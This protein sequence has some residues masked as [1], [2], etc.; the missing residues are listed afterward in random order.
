MLSW[1]GRQGTRAVAALVVLGIAFPSIGALLKPY[2]TEAVFILLCIAFLRVDIAAVRTY[3]RRPALVLTATA[4]TS[5]AIPVMFGM[6]CYAFGV[7]AKTPELFLALTLQAV[8]SPMMAAPALAALMGFDATLVLVTLVASTALVPFTAPLFAFLFVGSTL[9]ISP[10]M[11]AVKL[12][13]ILA[14]AVL[15]GFGVR[16]FFGFATIERQRE[17]INGLISHRNPRPLGVVE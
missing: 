10:P 15:V 12:I 13:A 7:N 4:W 1:L 9:S 2:V 16:R 8:A 17:R 6:S 14:G 5:A 3:V 11:L